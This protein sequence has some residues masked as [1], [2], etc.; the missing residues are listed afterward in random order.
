MAPAVETTNVLLVFHNPVD[1]DGCHNRLLGKAHIL[2]AEQKQKVKRTES[3]RGLRR[4]SSCIIPCMSWG[5]TRMSA[6][7]S[8]YLP[9]PLSGNRLLG[10][11]HILHAEQKQKVKRTESS[12]HKA[13]DS[14]EAKPRHPVFSYIGASFAEWFAA[15]VV[16]YYSLYVM[17][18]ILHAEQ[19]QKVKRTESSR[20]KAD[21]SPDSG[22][23]K[24]PE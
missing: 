8:G 20:H 13:D 22:N 19:K 16:M 7:Y 12:R 1:D 17:G 18:N 3:S 6:M 5:F 2:H 14:P 24:Y 9:L 4:P 23:G 11:A 21:D 15:A 10:K